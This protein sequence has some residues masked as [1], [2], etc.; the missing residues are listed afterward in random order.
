MSDSRIDHKED[1]PPPSYSTIWIGPP[2]TERDKSPGHDTVGISAMARV[3]RY[4]PLFFYCLEAYQAAFEEKFKGLPVTVRS[5]EK[6]CRQYS[7]PE[8]SPAIREA[9]E[10]L[11]SMMTNLLDKERNTVRDRATIKGHAAE[12]VL[13]I[14]GGYFADTNVAPLPD[15]E[16]VRL[17]HFKSYQF[18][19]FKENYLTAQKSL[20]G[21]FDIW[22]LYAPRQDATP[23]AIAKNFYLL[24]KEAEH[25]WQKSKY[26]EKYKMA[27]HRAELESIMFVF[28]VALLPPD[29]S[30]LENAWVSSYDHA[31]AQAIMPLLG[32]IKKYYGSHFHRPLLFDCITQNNKDAFCKALDAGADMNQPHDD[33][34]SEIKQETPLHYA[35]RMNRSEFVVIL[36]KRDANTQLKAKYPRYNDVSLTAEEL[37]KEE[38]GSRHAVLFQMIKLKSILAPD[39]K[40]NFFEDEKLFIQHFFKSDEISEDNAKKLL[41][42]LIKIA[43]HGSPLLT[44]FVRILKRNLSLT[45][46]LFTTN[47][48]AALRKLNDSDLQEQIRNALAV[49]TSISEMPERVKD[50]KVVLLAD[51]VRELDNETIA[52]QYYHEEKIDLT[53]SL[54]LWRAI[55]LK[56]SFKLALL[57][58]QDEKNF[59]RIGIYSD[60]YY[61][62]LLTCAV[63][64]NQLELVRIMLEKQTFDVDILAEA[65]EKTDNFA[66]SKLLTIVYIRDLLQ[67]NHDKSTMPN[68][69]FRLEESYPA[70][71]FDG[72]DQKQCE[73]LIEAVEK[74][75][76]NTLQTLQLQF[77]NNN[78]STLCLAAID[79]L[80]RYKGGSLEQHAPDAKQKK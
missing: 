17:P 73:A 3:N 26:S 80:I 75:D 43:E 44:A 18:P 66:M 27:I 46:L 77:N 71:Y 15:V 45:K 68:R 14:E 50:K 38:N 9:V 4:N 34:F 29:L 36:L 23:L 33:T 7:T 20:F 57:I 64:A 28:S 16:D 35:C 63:Q 22:L 25:E 41:N 1:R 60:D 55:F 24:W 74:E 70:G 67:L 47:F 59:M 76:L 52:C 37:D 39:A 31:N 40:D 11:S 79:Q 13:A 2:T 5:L 72:I 58:A 42:F 54:P 6:L 10:H 78:L 30:K 32:L 51:A 61:M 21:S 12:V 8:S 49:S 56:R 19:V 65:Y 69:L 48:F 53:D 62:N